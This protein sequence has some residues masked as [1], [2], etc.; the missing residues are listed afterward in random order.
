MIPK[1]IHQIWIQGG[2]KIPDK[3]LAM[4]EGCKRVNHNF[5]YNVWDDNQIQ[6]L[7][8]KYFEKK[9]LDT[10]NGY[11][12]YAQKADFARYAILYIYGGIY[13]DMDMTCKKNMEPFL[14][15]KMFFT[16]YRFPHLFKR[17]LNGIIGSVPKHPIFEVVF[18]NIFLRKDMG[19]SITN[20]TGTGLF[21]DS[22]TEY[23]KNHPNSNDFTIIDYRYLD[24]CHAFSGEDCI[25]ECTDCYVVHTSYSSWSPLIR[26][27]K[28][29]IKYKYLI[30]AIILTIIIII[31]ILNN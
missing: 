19:K 28:Q 27:G 14:Q 17:Y 31:I 25:H 16:T 22:V 26:M 8:E 23:S 11:M 21:Y 1:M 3:L 15:H 4:H 29:L 24:P 13:L 30:L 9:Y 7:L 12:V 6:K 10:Y 5:K 20:S 18:K 2:D